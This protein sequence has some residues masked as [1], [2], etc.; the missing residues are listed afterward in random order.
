MKNKKG[1]NTIL[2][3]FMIIIWGVVLYKVVNVFGAE[4]TLPEI[5]NTL[6]IQER[7]LLEFKKDTFV[8]KNVKRDPFLGKR[9]K[10]ELSLVPKLPEKSKK[11]A[12]SRNNRTAEV[13]PQ[14]QYYGFVKSDTKKGE[15]VLI[16]INGRLH[17]VR[18]GETI[19]TI[20]IKRVYRDSIRVENNRKQKTIKRQ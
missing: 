5:A 13:W 7:S 11:T 15:L 3:T 8:F 16:K 18:S 17:K 6:P 10:S 1:L 20:K 9:T 19:E 2:I 12:T 14:I 4:T